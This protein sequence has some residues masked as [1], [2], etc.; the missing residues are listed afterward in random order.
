MPTMVV[1]TTALINI[2]GYKSPFWCWLNVNSYSMLGF[3]FPLVV[4]VL[5][6]AAMLVAT[7]VKLHRKSSVLTDATRLK[8]VR[9]IPFVIFD[10]FIINSFLIEKYLFFKTLKRF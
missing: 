5:T 9:Y 2:E 3:I 8:S 10:K 1:M 7:T 6:T 4:A